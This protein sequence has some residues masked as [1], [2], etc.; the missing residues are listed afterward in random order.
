MSTSPSHAANALDTLDQ[1]L[2]H[3]DEVLFYKLS[4]AQTIQTAVI[5]AL[6]SVA[7]IVY[8]CA[9][10]RLWYRAN[11]TV[12]RQRIPT[13]TWLCWRGVQI[14]VPCYE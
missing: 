12:D 10:V 14:L 2:A 4:P 13:L 3:V 11:H 7:F 5:M 1:S 6:Q 9:S 8:F